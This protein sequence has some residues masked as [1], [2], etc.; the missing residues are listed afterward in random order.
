MRIPVDNAAIEAVLEKC[1][2]LR[3]EQPLAAIEILTEALSEHP[4]ARLY[5]SRG[6]AYERT[7]QPV[8]AVLD[9]THA[10]E[11]D[12][13]NAKY[14]YNRGCVRSHALNNDADAIPDFEQ[15]IKFAPD[16]VEAHQQC[17]LCLV[18]MA[19]PERACEHAT[20]AQ[21]LAPNDGLSHFCLGQALVRLKRYDEAVRSFER[22]VELNPGSANDWWTLGNARQ[23]VGGNELL[24]FAEGDYSR[25]IELEPT[26]ASYFCSRGQVR[27]ELG[28][29]DEAVADFRY[30]LT[31]NPNEYQL[32]RINR[33]LE[34]ATQP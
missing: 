11:L 2:Q 8:M 24:I 30:A 1:R 22:A 17:C 34:Q 16:H 19:N 4:D 21:A 12:P 3:V 15:A 29:V 27:L 10:I 5:F 26:S 14:Y 18:L 23:R 28:L 9:Y 32:A 13:T 6:V 20:A 25:A 31:L 7:E 33:Y